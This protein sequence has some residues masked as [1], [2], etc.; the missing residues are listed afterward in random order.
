MIYNPDVAHILTEQNDYLDFF[1]S[2]KMYMIS[3]P[4][5]SNVFSQTEMFSERR[6]DN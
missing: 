3:D 6:R 1:L 5:F 2:Q 4:Q